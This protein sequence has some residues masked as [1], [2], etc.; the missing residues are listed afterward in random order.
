MS[1]RKL[2]FSSNS[3]HAAHHACRQSVLK[4]SSSPNGSDLESEGFVLPVRKG[5]THI[6]HDVYVNK[7]G[8][9]DLFR[10]GY[11]REMTD[12]TH[13][14]PILRGMACVW[15]VY[16]MCMVCVWHVYG[17]KQAK[18]KLKPLWLPSFTPPRSHRPCP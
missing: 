17:S 8:A 16:G 6:S 15:H 1:F 9:P 3:H 7:S 4:P 5:R 18:A 10:Q 11:T 2:F 13:P 12:I 14:Y